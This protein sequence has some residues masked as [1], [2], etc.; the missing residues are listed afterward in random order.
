MSP[1]ETGPGPVIVG[2]DGSPESDRALTWAAAEAA[3]HGRP[4]KIVHG[5]LWPDIHAYLGPS[6]DGP[7]DGG[8]EAAAH[9]L[10]AAAEASAQTAVPGIEVSTELAITAPAAR[11]IELSHTADLIVVGN[12]GLGGFTG[13]IAGSVSV[14][15]AS[16]AHCP[17]VVVRGPGSE[18]AEPTTEQPHAGQVVVGIDGSAH[19]EAALEFAF[20]EASL[21]GTG[22][23]AI[24]AWTVPVSTG[25]GDM[26]P[27][28]YDVDVINEEEMRLLSELLAG[29]QG[30]YPD[31]PVRRRVLHT[32]PAKELVRASH[33]AELLVVGA[34]GRGGFRGLLL[35]SVSHA[36]IHHSACPVAVV[37]GKH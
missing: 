7:P 1:A 10:V 19:G 3:R 28:V 5:F 22:V 20:S 34:R 33:G 18:G 37:R 31:V 6:P 32:A 21:R 12:R 29:W 36:A 17:V 2:V 15:V 13:L 30:K 35:G 9:E 16:H 25:P 14:Q 4:L 8:L 24:H 26:L 27:L 11:L 23:T